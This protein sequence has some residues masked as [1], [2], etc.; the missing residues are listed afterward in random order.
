MPSFFFFF[1]FFSFLVYNS[2]ADLG[3]GHFLKINDQLGL[4]APGCPSNGPSAPPS[5]SFL[6]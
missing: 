3:S 1:L 5:L 6:L 4:M 2:N